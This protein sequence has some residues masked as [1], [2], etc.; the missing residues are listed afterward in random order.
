MLDVAVQL[1]ADY[2]DK[3]SSR[4]LRYLARYPTMSIF[5]YCARKLRKF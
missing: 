4:K 5:A 2:S 1:S 3:R